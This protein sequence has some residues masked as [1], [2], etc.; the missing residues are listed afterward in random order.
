MIAPKN[1]NGD[2]GESGKSGDSGKSVYQVNLGAS[3]QALAELNSN[4]DPR[5][6]EN[7][8]P[9]FFWIYHFKKT[10]ILKTFY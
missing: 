1:K 10:M 2:S 6:L 8:M 3:G 7:K 5:M 4:P 9:E